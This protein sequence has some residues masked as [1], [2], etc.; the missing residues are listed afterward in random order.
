MGQPGL[1]KIS[2]PPPEFYNFATD[3][4]DKWAAEKK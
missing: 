3:V 1:A 2:W 4:V